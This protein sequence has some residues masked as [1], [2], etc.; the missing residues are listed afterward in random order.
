MLQRK[1]GEM[2]LARKRG[3]RNDE[4]VISLVTSRQSARPKAQR[5]GLFSGNFYEVEIAPTN[6]VWDREGAQQVTA[7]LFQPARDNPGPSVAF[8]ERR[9]HGQ[10]FPGGKTP[11]D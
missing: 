4:P 3:E 7:K 8:A 1:I 10:V 6:R 2:N 5:S 11:V 9:W